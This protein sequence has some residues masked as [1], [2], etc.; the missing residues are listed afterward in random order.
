MLRYELS[1]LEVCIAKPMPSHKVLIFA[2]SMM[3]FWLFNFRHLVIN[4]STSIHA[5]GGFYLGEFILRKLNHLA[6]QSSLLRPQSDLPAV[7]WFEVQE[8]LS[9][10]GAAS[11]H[12]K[13]STESAQWL[14]ESKEGKVN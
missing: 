7:L 3:C 9:A 11:G 13:W 10:W 1:N 14:A 12:S 6:W 8:Q 5:W 2:F 4:P